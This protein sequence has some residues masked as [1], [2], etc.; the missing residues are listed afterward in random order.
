MNY[1]SA[2][3][4]PFRVPLANT[5]TPRF[6]C[7]N[8]AQKTEDAMGVKTAREPLGLRK[9][10]AIVG[11]TIALSAVLFLLLDLLGLPPKLDIDSPRNGA[12]V[13]GPS[14]N[15]TG[16]AKPGAEI[17]HDVGMSNDPVVAIAD[18]QGRWSCTWHLRSG[19]N[20][21]RLHTRN[22]EDHVTLTVFND[23][24]SATGFGGCAG[25]QFF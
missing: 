5:T 18:S 21:I 25:R 16:R 1:G 10:L 19:K 7:R 20:S 13:A 14:V 3:D 9:V 15:V 23:G 8:L 17:L 6:A 22:K 2:G 24:P 11:L 12:H 4:E